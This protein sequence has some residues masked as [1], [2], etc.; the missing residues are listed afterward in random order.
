MIIFLYGTDAYRSRRKLNEIVKNFR[1]REDKAG[2]NTAVFDAAK[3]DIGDIQQ[4]L[5]SPA[6]LGNKR[7][8]VVNGLLAMKRDEQKPFIELVEKLPASTTAVFYETAENKTLEKSPLFEKLAAGKYSWEFSPMNAGQMVAWLLSEAAEKG[9]AFDPPAAAALV[10]A[11][12][13]DSSRAHNELLKLTAYVGERKIIA[14]ADVADLVTN[15]PQD[16]IFGFLDAVANKQPKNAAM[17]L[18]QQ[19]ASGS[20]PMQLLAMLARTVR[21]LIMAKDLLERGVPQSEAVREL[22]IHPFAARK[23]LT[24]ARNFEMNSLKNLHAALLDADR[25]IK[26]GSVSSPRVALD[27]LVARAVS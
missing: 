22:G 13:S 27:M 16:D 5:F 4:A 14:V 1:E 23:A 19:V 18:E 26:T 3:T 9:V 10:E 24:Q 21:L 2:L 12:G 17:M 20:E 25:K 15:E 11:V 7:L 6:F 8:V